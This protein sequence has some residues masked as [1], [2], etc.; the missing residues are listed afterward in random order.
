MNFY[1]VRDLR[2]TPRS[3]WEDLS[4]DG[5]VVIT[6][7][8][9]PT[10]LLFDIGD[11]DLEETLKAVRQA[12]AMIAFN[13]MRAKAAEKGFLSEEEIEAEIAAAR[14]GE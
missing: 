12:K 10:A 6:N 4:E 11:G 3:V 14:R 13:S 1:T 9:K 2:T 8:G 5:E 7:N